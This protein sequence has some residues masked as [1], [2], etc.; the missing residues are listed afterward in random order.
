MTTISQALATAAD[1]HRAGPFG[2]AERIY[3]SILQAHPRHPDALHLL[4][5]IAHEAGRDDMA[6]D[7]IR[8]AITVRADVA[9][10]HGSLG[11]AYQALGQRDDAVR[12]FQETLRLK[13]DY[14]EGHNNLG[15]VLKSQGRLVEAEAEFR[16][17]I[18]LSSDF[19]EAHWNLAR[20]LEEKGKPD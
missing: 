17:A 10:F 11:L 12:A 16:E 15:A 14:A 8:Q 9:A 7:Y 19:A 3:R 18:R 5:L 6:V 2:P 1:H 4:G 20:L 13:P